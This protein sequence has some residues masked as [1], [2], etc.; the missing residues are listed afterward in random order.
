MALER[1]AVS[2]ETEIDQERALD[3]A[4]A[5]KPMGLASFPFSS[6]A[7]GARVGR[8]RKERAED[9]D[10]DAALLSPTPRLSMGL[11]RRTRRPRGARQ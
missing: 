4:R 1:G 10:H 7:R 2:S 8:E 6:S 3:A 9:A 11:V 5:K